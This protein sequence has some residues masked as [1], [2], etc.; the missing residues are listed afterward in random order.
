M[1]ESDICARQMQ[2]RQRG[3]YPLF[4]RSKASVRGESRREGVAFAER[5]THRENYC[6]LDGI[7]SFNSLSK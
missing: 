3:Q 2:M 6:P 4:K 1:A 5:L 7:Q